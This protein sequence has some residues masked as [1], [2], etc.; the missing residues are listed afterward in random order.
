[1]NL[2]THAAKGVMLL[3]C[4]TA[5]G[6]TKLRLVHTRVVLE[7]WEFAAI[8]PRWWHRCVTENKVPTEQNWATWQPWT[9]KESSTA[10]KGVAQWICRAFL[11]SPS[12]RLLPPSPS[13]PPPTGSPRG[14]GQRVGCHPGEL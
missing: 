8:H 4:P 1:M 12:G 9:H 13:S 3:A 10:P 2:H 11:F 14:Y 5:F 6:P 7:K